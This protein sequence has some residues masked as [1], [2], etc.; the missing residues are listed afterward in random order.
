MVHSGH[1]KKKIT[2]VPLQYVEKEQYIHLKL[3]K[4][5]LSKLLQCMICSNVGEHC[6]STWLDVIRFNYNV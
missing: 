3:P 4:I 1:N 6:G 2:F 5:S